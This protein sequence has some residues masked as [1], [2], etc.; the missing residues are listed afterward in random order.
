[1]A[2]Q[3][4]SLL[5]RCLAAGVAVCA[6]YSLSG[7]FV[8]SNVQSERSCRTLRG[9][10]ADGGWVYSKTPNVDGTFWNTVGYLPDGTPMNR[11]GNAVN[12]PEN[13]A[14]DSHTPGSALPK[15]YYLNSIGYLPDGTPMNRA[16]N[17]VNHP[18]TIGADLH[19]DGSPL[20]PPLKGFVNAIGYLPDG[21]DMKKAGNLANKH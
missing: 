3:S 10:H 5:G 13:I 20:L 14:K 11:A 6:A 4:R 17:W 18:E 16:G 19:K 2:V 15:S 9:A 8:G 21:T 1:M 12:H 7:A